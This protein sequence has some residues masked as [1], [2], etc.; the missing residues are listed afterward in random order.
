LCGRGDAGGLQRL[1]GW[2]ALLG[3]PA[4]AV[5]GCGGYG[6]GLARLLEMT[7]CL[8]CECERPRRGDRKRGQNDLIDA[9]LAA[10]RL[11]S[12]SGLSTPRG[13]GQREQLRVL[14]V[15]WRGATQA[16][17]AALNQLH[18]LVV[19]APDALRERL[20][21][22]S[23]VQ[24]VKTAARLR[25]SPDGGVPAPTV[26]VSGERYVL[27]TTTP[28][29]TSTFGTV[30]LSERKM[31][32]PTSAITEYAEVVGTTTD[33][34]PLRGRVEEADQPSGRGERGHDIRGGR[35]VPARARARA[36]GRPRCLLGFRQTC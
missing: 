32:L 31:A 22:L 18:A 21:G 24:L 4:F 12:G 26:P 5:E 35:L 29:T 2:A 34:S 14:L 7:G 6:A 23:N 19:T 15:E 9:V 30:M 8:V 11:L 25:S 16:R 1:L 33:A 28:A 20:T 36:D 13:G 27:I 10:R 3:E 17:T